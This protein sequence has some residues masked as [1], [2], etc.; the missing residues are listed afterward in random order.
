MEEKKWDRLVVG[1]GGS[2]GEIIATLAQLNA[3][4]FEVRGG[5]T[6]GEA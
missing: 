6:T 5:E 2:G 3:S 4:A 1:R